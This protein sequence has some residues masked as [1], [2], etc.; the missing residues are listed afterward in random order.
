MTALD[1]LKAR[2]PEIEAL[3]ANGKSIRQ[4]A[5]ALNGPKKS[6]V[7]SALKQMGLQT[8]LVTETNSNGVKYTP[9]YPNK[10]WLAV[11]K[12]TLKGKGPTAIHKLLIASKAFERIPTVF[13]IG[14]RRREW[15][16]GLALSPAQQGILESAVKSNNGP[17]VIVWKKVKA[18]LLSKR[19]QLKNLNQP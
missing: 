11:W 2:R 16:M 18:M 3:I 17:T 12:L 8:N 14:S 19:K 6:V 7:F 13:Q 1:R 4:I 10:V 9:H 5:V 15:K